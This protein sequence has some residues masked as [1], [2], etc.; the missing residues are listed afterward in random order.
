MKVAQIKKKNSAQHSI[1]FIDQWRIDPILQDHASAIGAHIIKRKEEY[2]LFFPE[3]NGRFDFYGSRAEVKEKLRF[4]HRPLVEVPR[5]LIKD[6]YRQSAD[7]TLQDKWT[8]LTQKDRKVRDAREELHV[9]LRYVLTDDTDVPEYIHSSLA[10]EGAECHAGPQQMMEE[11]KMRKATSDI[12][13]TGRVDSYDQDAESEPLESAL[14]PG[15]RFDPRLG[16]S[17]DLGRRII[18]PKTK[19]ELSMASWFWN[20]V[21]NSSDGDYVING[22]RLYLTPDQFERFCEEAYQA[23]KS[24]KIQNLTGDI[25]HEDRK[26]S[27]INDVDAGL[28]NLQSHPAFEVMIRDSILGQQDPGKRFYRLLHA[29]SALNDM[30]G[31]PA[32]DK[33]WRFHHVTDRHNNPAKESQED[34]EVLL[35]VL[36]HYE[37]KGQ[38]NNITLEAIAWH[39]QVRP[40]LSK[41]RSFMEILEGDL[42][43]IKERKK[44][45][46]QQ[47]LQKQYAELKDIFSQASLAQTPMNPEQMSEEY[48]DLLELMELT[49][50]QGDGPMT[51]MVKKGAEGYYDFMRDLIWVA[52]REAPIPTIILFAAMYGLTKM[53]ASVWEMFT[54]ADQDAVAQVADNMSG[55][56]YNEDVQDVFSEVFGDLEGDLPELSG[57]ERTKEQELDG[58]EGIDYHLH[59]IPGVGTYKHWFKQSIEGT[60]HTLA[61]YSDL[62]LTKGLNALDIETVQDPAYMNSA[63]QAAKDSATWAF[64]TNL[65]QNG[66][67]HFLMYSRFAM[68]NAKFGP[69]GFRHM[70]KFFNGTVDSMRSA[71]WQ[72]PAIIA[73]GITGA[74]FDFYKPAKEMFEQA[75][76]ANESFESGLLFTLVGTMIGA[77][78]PAIKRYG[79]GK[80]AETLS[81][82]AQ[83]K[84]DQALSITLEDMTHSFAKGAI[85][86]DEVKVKLRK[87]GLKKEFAINAENYNEIRH[88]LDQMAM[89]MMIFANEAGAEGQFYQLFVKSKLDHVISAMEDY[90]DGAIPAED[91]IAALKEN[92][93][94]VVAAQMHLTGTSSIYEILY[95]H[96][97]EG[98]DAKHLRMKGN[99]AHAHEDRQETN[100]EDRSK[101]SSLEAQYRYADLMP[102]QTFMQR[103]DKFARKTYL[104][105]LSIGNSVKIGGR[106]LW[107]N[108]VNAT[109]HI[110]HGSAEV[111]HKGKMAA[112]VGA[113][114]LASIVLN[115]AGYTGPMS[116]IVDM[117]APAVSYVGTATSATG[118][119]LVINYLDDQLVVHTI[120]GSGAALTGMVGGYYG[121]KKGAGL[122]KR[123]ADQKLNAKET[124]EIIEMMEQRRAD[125]QQ[126]RADIYSLARDSHSKVKVEAMD[127]Q[128]GLSC[129]FAENGQCDRLCVPKITA[130]ARKGQANDNDDQKHDLHSMSQGMR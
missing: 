57:I 26:T 78:V 49:T 44:T 48:K 109:R 107:D 94:D 35:S 118:V 32:L 84:I 111:P 106:Q 22:G 126:G 81:K 116:E 92:L 33:E 17:F 63:K 3:G 54:S 98:K 86:I 104:S 53:D 74:I 115:K 59:K 67:A 45:S 20:A 36:E 101:N 34:L 50:G 100:A 88:A 69:T 18:R 2:A 77:A 28:Q 40:F 76:G 55:G 13:V 39:P 23:V 124:A 113:T 65:F 19:T 125:M 31:D 7:K 6:E 89:V 42:N 97:P 46:E 90:K 93:D 43:R 129:I 96:A 128:E 16:F 105:T 121:V 66:P 15:T 91:L 95:G 80:F 110:R 47:V 87:F 72:K 83:E 52:P 82:S 8:Y 24:D 38:I 112:A 99:Y 12:D 73:G 61:S 27:I 102:T 41:A 123:W 71:A 85:A 103:Y 37:A 114:A 130:M 21:E 10:G 119:F 79:K 25:A 29:T 64:I 56:N 30:L 4:Y 11:D 14:L 60:A 75:V 120:L 62:A 117:V 122:V 9:M 70:W 51:R 58:I 68:Q 108:V 127:A 1:G 5:R